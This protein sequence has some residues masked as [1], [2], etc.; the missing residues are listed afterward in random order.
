MCTVGIDGMTCHSCVSLIEST[1]GELAGVRHVTISLDQK[2]GTVEYDGR[3][4]TAEDIRSGIDD[5]GFTVTYVQ[6]ESV[7]NMM[8]GAHEPPKAAKELSTA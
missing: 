8:P 6:G 5:M 1:V 3:A 7:G 4:V 2:Q